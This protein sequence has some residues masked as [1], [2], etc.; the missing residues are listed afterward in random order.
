MCGA[1]W[2]LGG[3]A[4]TSVPAYA[5]G[6]SALPNISPIARERKIAPEAFSGD[7]P[8]QA[9]AALWNIPQFL[10]DARRKQAPIK[11]HSVP[12]TIIGAGIA[13]LSLAYLLKDKAPLILEQAPQLGGNS[14]GENWCGLDYSIGAAY[15]CEPEEGT[16]I[17]DFLADL[18]LVKEAKI[19][20]DEGPMLYAGGLLRDFWSGGKEALSGAEKRQIEVLK[21]YFEDMAA[22]EKIPY[23]ELPAGDAEAEAY[24]HQLDAH[25]F[26]DHLCAQVGEPL[27]AL[28][29]AAIEHYCWSSLGG[30]AREIS[31]AAGLN[32]YA[33]EFNNLWVYPGGNAAIA[34]RI[35]ERLTQVLPLQNICTSSL[36]LEVDP[37]P[38]GVRVTWL[39]SEGELE[40]VKSKVVVCACPK[41]VA[42]KIVRGLNEQR[43]DAFQQLQY[44]AYLVANAFLSTNL[45]ENVYDIF[46]LG[47][48]EQSYAD[49]KRAASLRGATDVINAN[50]AA[51]TASHSVL[52]L[53]RAL[54]YEGGRAELYSP[55]AFTRFEGELRRQ[56]HEEL[57]PGLGVDVRQLRGLRLARWGHPLPLAKTGMY[58]AGL[59]AKLSEPYEKRVFFVNQD[60]HAL[61]AFETSVTE[62]F[63]WAARI[64]RLL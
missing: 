6:R 38:D 52:T 62:A 61:P 14:K 39:N 41:F 2:I 27:C 33:A 43:G 31:A 3:Q 63:A 26:Y 23:P 49:T 24:I 1:G 12:L 44:R 35:S 47:A 42:K 7:N 20:S 22:G 56:L 34:E 37:Q 25:S 45:E 55:D 57:L 8:T 64:K 19:K 53:Y 9:H 50:F 21:R 5:L 32:F 15:V 51:P 10:A 13:G 16:E 28:I 30:S 46:A 54:P 29:N 58:R 48:G 17:A 18:G 59:P 4:F 11:P 36:V 40:E 60:N